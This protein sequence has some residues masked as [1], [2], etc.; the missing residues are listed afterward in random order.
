MTKW[1]ILSLFGLAI[2]LYCREENPTIGKLCHDLSPI[3]IYLFS[4]EKTT[5]ELTGNIKTWLSR[6]K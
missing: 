1:A 6:L 2:S 5:K 4:G 3:H